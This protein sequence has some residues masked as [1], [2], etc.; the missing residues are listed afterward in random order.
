MVFIH[1]E[2][3]AGTG[4]NHS[5]IFRPVVEGVVGVG[6]S[7]DGAGLTFSVGA[8]TSDSAAIGR[9]GRHADVKVLRY[10]G[11]VG[12]QGVVAVHGEGVG[13]IGGNH[14]TVFC[15]I[16]EG[17]VGVGSSGDCAGLTFGISAAAS[18]GATIG[19]IGRHTDGE[20]LRY[21]SEVGHQ[22]VVAVHGEGVAGIGGNHSTVFRPV[23]EGVV[24]AGCG[25]NS[26]A[27]AVCKAAAA[28]DS[29]AIGRVGRHA[30]GVSV[31]SEVSHKA[32]V[33]VHGEGVIGVGGN[34]SAVFRPV[35]ESVACGWRG[36]HC[37]GLTFSVGAFASDGAAIG[38]VGRHADGIILGL[39]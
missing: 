15:P 33:A 4:R 36:T 1:G 28:G 13:G 24:G 32:V 18:D 10:V 16:V 34:H 6:C 2:G 14:S 20:V 22:G 7:G 17:I 31:G 39:F 8:A 38:R 26:A 12:H 3:V 35:G 25:S 19:R 29:A 9:V 21:V 37:A 5:A 27:L 30:D 11:E 23:V